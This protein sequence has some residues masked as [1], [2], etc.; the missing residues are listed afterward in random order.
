MLSKKYHIVLLSLLI[1]LQGL[2]Q[3][4]QIFETFACGT[5]D[6]PGIYEE[7]A[8]NNDFDDYWT[9][10]PIQDP[11]AVTLTFK[12][13]SC[14]ALDQI[15]IAFWKGDERRMF[16][17]IAVAE[18][19]EGP[20]SIAIG[21]TES[22]GTTEA[23]E[24]FTF[25]A[26]IAEYVSIIGHGNS[27][28][29][30]QWVSIT[31]VDIYGEPAA[32]DGSALNGEIVEATSCD[33]GECTDGTESWDPYKCECFSIPPID[34]IIGCT[35]PDAC[36]FNPDATCDDNSCFTT[37]TC[38]SDICAGD[39]EIIDPEDPCNCLIDIPQILGCTDPNS[40]NYDSAANCDD[41]SCI[42]A[43]TCN[44]DICMGDVEII[45][46]NDPCNC[47]ID[48]V[49]VLGCSDPRAENYNP[50]T[51]CND[52]SCIYKTY[53][54]NIISSMSSSLNNSFIIASSGPIT[55]LSVTIHNRWGEPVSSSSYSTIDSEII[56]WDGRCKDK[57]CEQ[58]V[59]VYLIKY[60]QS[61]QSHV[62]TGDLTVIR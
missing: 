35:N 40:C 56:L 14:F 34:L 18:N 32:C 33:N 9:G 60:T 11:P 27:A 61:D 21:P 45:D 42:S 7:N 48:I 38:N 31:E 36:N 26:V 30:D 24:C 4:L 54:P 15:C 55:D 49:Q 37:I 16:F 29:G 43:P 25:P 6:K 44:E 3:E 50:E 57:E 10:S 52:G 12:L 59:Y 53:V 39:V 62:L 13:G 41:N 5:E 17:S 58:G 46:P 2:S 8:Y 23:L 47:L 1:T 22:S 51:N 28:G 19:I 20:Y